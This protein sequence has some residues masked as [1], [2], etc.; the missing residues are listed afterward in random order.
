MTEPRISIITPC[1]NRAATIARAV[2]SVRAQGYPE[3]EHILIDGGSSDGTL[4]ILAQYPHLRVTSGPD[5]GMY[6]ALNKGLALARGQI[7]GFLNSDDFYGE[8]I[9][10][11]VAYAFRDP[12]TQAVTGAA[13]VSGQ[14]ASGETISG[15]RFQP[16]NADLL[17]L[18]ATGNPFFNAWFFRRAVF[19]QIGRFDASLHIAADREFMLR[20]ALSRPRYAVISPMVYHYQQHAGSLTFDLTDAKFQRIAAEHITITSRFLSQKDLPAPARALIRDLRSRDTA[21]MFAISLKSGNLPRAARCAAAGLQFDPAWAFK[22]IKKVA[23]Y[24]LTRNAE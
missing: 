14:S 3:T 10:Q 8:T 19:E 18:A 20:F 24:V 11:A 15:E 22:L 1:L 13:L 21:K 17:Q 16:Q 2:E 4:P 5:S 7:I 23:G 6:D 9:F 12:Q